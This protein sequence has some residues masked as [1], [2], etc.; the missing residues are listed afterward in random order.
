MSVHTHLEPEI[1]GALSS[2]LTPG[3]D[4]RPLPSERD[5]NYRVVSGTES[6]V[7]KV[8]A[9]GD[10]DWLELQDRALRQIRDIDVSTPHPLHPQIVRLEDGR[11]VR[12]VNW[13]DGAPW[14]TSELTIDHSRSLG[15][16]VALVDRGLAGMHLTEPDITALTRSFRWNMM[17]AGSLREHLHLVPHEDLAQACREV[18]D[19]FV[20]DLLPRLDDL[21]AQ[22]IHNDANDHNIMVNDTT[23]GIIDFGDIIYAPRVIGL[24]TCLAYLPRIGVDPLESMLP[25]VRGYHLASP[26]SVA[27]VSLMWDLVQVR[28]VMS[29]INAAIQTSA[30][31]GNDYLG[32]SQ[33]VVPQVLLAMRT[34]SADFATYAFRDACGFDAA[35]Q[36]RAIRE[37]LLTTERRADVLGRDWS[38]L[39]W[40]VLDW[41]AGSTAPRTAQDVEHLRSTSVL[42]A[43]IGRYAEDRDVYQSDLFDLSAQDPRTL[44]LGV[45]IFVADGQSIHAPLDGVIEAFMVDEEP[46]GY[47]PVVVLRHQTALGV[48][49]FTLYGHLSA[50]SI[51]DWSVGRSV[52]AGEVLGQIGGPTENGGWAPHVHIQVL[53]DL[54]DKGADV[55]GVAPRGSASLWRSLSPNPNLLLRIGPGIDAHADTGA[56]AIRAEREVR[57]GRNLSLN[58]REPLEI[59]RGEGAYLYDVA[60]KSY[61]DLVNNVAH[62]GHANPYVTAAAARQQETLNTNT[63]YLHPTIV[64]FARN[65]AATLPDPLSV[66]YF[67]NS[68]SEAN[69]LA[70]RM[71]RA[72]TGNHG[73][74]ALRHAYH[75]HTASVIDISPYKFLGKGGAGVPD[76]V[77]V[78][79]LP[80]AF[81]GPHRGSG[82]GEAYAADFAAVTSG[83]DRGLAAF[84]SES[85][86]ST[87]GQVTLADGFLSPAFAQTRMAGGVC[88]ADEV[89]IG[90]GRVGEEF[91]GFQ[92]HDVVPDIV[93]MGKPLGNGHPLAAVVTTPDIAAAFNNGMEYFNTFGGNPVSTAIG[94]AVLDVVQGQGL[95]AHAEQVGHYLRTG[96]RH[97]ASQHSTIADVRGHGLFI[98]VE[99]LD[100]AGGPAT[101]RTADVI[102]HAKQRGV[103]LSSDGP[104][105][106]VLKIKPPMV[107]QASDVDFFLEVLDVA[108]QIS[109]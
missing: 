29:V 79:E 2:L 85:I 83:F 34:T 10:Q 18:L 101:Q 52:S 36:A 82:A 68:G 33:D 73:F 100:D 11:C 77:R 19:H 92:L 105:D 66:V 41:S 31:P 99:L 12:L 67:V 22:V 15:R 84:I 55:W 40:D 46:L 102:N 43:L 88:I 98:G 51:H 65:L 3:A 50:S 109:E 48:P 71:A 103:F 13:V 89:Q 97:L 93:T 63:R 69:D 60:G 64:E 38:E 16:A 56:T 14:A 37:H 47:G 28:L 27:E 8:H 108:L 17:Q 78:A 57:L 42:D 94:Q 61:L 5:L 104:G 72:Y 24:A 49:F 81:K 107:I 58:F 7:L 25:V 80:D 86:V 20:E 62:V 1:I 75:G 26:L 6:V 106:N 23:I 32:I 96:V 30:D 70:M 90:M 74:I 39:T 54:L 35:P 76:Y 91:W 53:V 4:I 9:P 45:D 44:H 21:P 59:V 87:A 95:Q